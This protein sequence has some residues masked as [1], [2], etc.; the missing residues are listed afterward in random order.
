MPNPTRAKKTGDN[1]PRAAAHHTGQRNRRIPTAS[2]EDNRP[3][4]SV[5]RQLL[6]II[7]NRNPKQTERLLRGGTQNGIKPDFNGTMQ[8]MEAIQL[9]EDQDDCFKPI[10]RERKEDGTATTGQ[11]NYAYDWQYPKYVVRSK[12]NSHAEPQ[13]LIYLN[14]KEKEGILISELA[15]CKD[16]REDIENLETVEGMTI[17]VYYYVNYVDKGGAKNKQEILDFYYRKGYITDPYGDYTTQLTSKG[18]KI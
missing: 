16:C 9:P 7:Q 12:S 14:K 18:E 15:P 13:L 6:T 2:L 1:T 4:A 10:F 11:H 8:R 17:N 5:Q 3:A